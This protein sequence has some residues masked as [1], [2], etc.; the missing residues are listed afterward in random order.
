MRAEMVGDALL[1]K[2]R[3]K[4]LVVADLHLGLVRWYDRNLIEKLER[5]FH[6]TGADEIVVLGD[7]KHR[8][9][10]MRVEFDLPMTVVRGNHDG[11]LEG[12]EIVDHIVLGKFGLF[13]G[14]F[15]PD[16]DAKT[17]VFAHAH[18]SVMIDGVKERVWMFGEFEG[19]RIVVMPAF[20]DL[21]SSTPVNLRRPAG[22]MF[23]RWDYKNAE[24]VTLEGVYLG[25]VGF[26]MDSTSRTPHRARGAP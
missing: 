13:H 23:K 7:L 17:L 22:A 2:G 10:G 19:K 20:N 25:T 8:I 18:P 3:R 6:E 16:L 26:L 12:V 14:H 11:K 4:V 24:I 1:F 21:C 9:G 15:V 5:T